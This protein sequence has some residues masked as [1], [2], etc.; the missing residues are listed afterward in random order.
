MTYSRA[1]P[2]LQTRGKKGNRSYFVSV[3]I[4]IYVYIIYV[5][6]I[7]LFCI[8]FELEGSRRCDKRTPRTTT[9]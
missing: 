6:G 3:F 8:S 2:N 9:N 5:E 1:S 7:Y 4:N